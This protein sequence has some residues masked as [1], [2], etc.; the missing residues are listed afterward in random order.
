MTQL[1]C[2][3]PQPGCT[4]GLETES[5]ITDRNNI[6]GS[7]R[8]LT[9][10]F[11]AGVGFAMLAPLASMIAGPAIIVAV[12]S[13]LT[14]ANQ[15]YF[16]TFSSLL[17]FQIL[18]DMGSAQVLLQFASH[19]WSL[20]GLDKVGRITGNQEALAKLR[21]LLVFAIRWAIGIAVLAGTVLGLAGAAMFSH[22]GGPDVPWLGPWV[23]LCTVTALNMLMTPVW[24]LLEGCNRI[25]QV[26]AYRFV[27]NVAQNGCLCCALCAG[28]GLWAI[29]LGA[30]AVFCVSVNMLLRKHGG[31]LAQVLAAGHQARISWR[32]EL[33]PV[34]WRFALSWWSGY[35]LT[36]SFTPILFHYY[37]P[38][39]AGQMGM[40][41][42]VVATIAAVSTAW[43]STRAARFGVLIAR[44]EYKELD[45]MAVRSGMACVGVAAVGAVGIESLVL[46]LHSIGSP[47]A[48]RI[49]APLPTGLFLAG[50]VLMQASA[51][52]AVYL[53]AH[54]REPF[55]ALSA[56]AALLVVGSSC[57]FGK[58]YG[59][60]GAA[61]S[62]CGVTLLFILPA[63]TAILMKCRRRW[64]ECPQ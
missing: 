16:Y 34:Q 58:T 42:S 63:G 61:A 40:T 50:Q 59:V 30:T 51:V 62:Y 31:F 46:A 38:A 26:Y 60:V 44:R 49:L 11:D 14:P 21:S 54:K 45:R 35:F 29:P 12:I 55:A 52:E 5:Q 36:Y 48:N 41:W 25:T 19:E 2:S 47:L 15:G 64:H 56:T 24:A 18:F 3:P 23:M 9:D 43:V 6:W 22:S 10:A 17:A 20:L 4:R 39:V 27:A 33:L 37:G 57:Y 53:R 32:H 8:S 1:G 28:G 7:V 13:R